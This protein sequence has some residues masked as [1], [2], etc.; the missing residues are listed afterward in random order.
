MCLMI[1]ATGY[2]E[3]QTQGGLF[4][5]VAQLDEHLTI[6]PPAVMSILLVARSTRDFGAHDGRRD[7]P[8]LAVL[9]AA[10]EVPRGE[11][12]VSDDHGHSQ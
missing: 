7:C 11:C 5:P 8:G 9:S 12:T 6:T 2:F 10:F 3:D 1:E 4:Q